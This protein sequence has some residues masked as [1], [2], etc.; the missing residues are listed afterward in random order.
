MRED[1]GFVQITVTRTGDA[2]SAGTI[3]YATTGGTASGQRNYI[4]AIGTLSFATGETTKSFAVL[5]TDNSYVEGS[6]TVNLS[7]S[8]PTGALNLGTPNA[9]T[10]TIT[11]N[12]TQP[13]IRNPIDDAEFFVRQQYHDFLNREPDAGGLAYWTGQIAACGA[14]QKCLNTKRRDVSAAFFIEQEYQQTGFYVYRVF[15]ASYGR[16]PAYLDYVRGRTQVIGGAD[17]ATGQTQYARQSVNPAYS[18]LSADK[19]VDQLFKNIGVMPGQAERD[20]FVTNLNS[21]RESRA[22]VLQKI[23]DNTTF[24][25]AEYNPAFVLAEYF[26]Y[27]RRDPDPDGYKFW[28]DVLNNR[29][30]NNYRSM[31]CA[32][33]TSTEYQQRFSSIIT[34]SD[35]VCGK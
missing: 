28:L 10:L 12:D 19:Y 34:R 14:E 35:S 6:M 2:S 3:D 4:T 24:A 7:L 11:D 30:L 27:L 32:F 29:V 13:P 18:T 33:I 31:V 5:L 8:N 1:A 22:S 20:A 16:Q 9:A 21:G 26:S 25:Q 23:A 17:L 15:K